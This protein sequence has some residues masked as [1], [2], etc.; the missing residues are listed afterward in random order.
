MAVEYDFDPVA[1]FD[2]WYKRRELSDRTGCLDD[3]ELSEQASSVYQRYEHNK[4]EMD[5]RCADFSK[6]LK[7]ADS[8]VVSKKNDLPNVSS[9]EV[10][11][12]VRRIARALVQN[13]PNVEV[14]SEFDDDSI[15]GVLAEHILKSKV[16]G[17]DE[18]SNDMQQNLFASTK[19]ALTIGFDAVVPCLLQQPDGSWYVEYDTIHHRDVFPEPGA[20]DVRRATEVFVRR[21]LTLGEVK[22]L[23][24][25]QVD[26]WDHDALRTMLYRMPKPPSRDRESNPHA[27]NERKVIAEGYEVITWYT[28]GGADFLT[29]CPRTKLLLR[30]EKNKHPRKLHPVFFLVLEK[31][32]EQPLGKSQVELVYGR[33]EFQDLMH[34]GAM[35][36]WY[37]NINPPLLG[38]GASNAIPNM[39]PGKYTPISNPNAKIEPFEV[40]TQTLLQYPSIAQGNLG[41]MVN[42]VGA[43]DQQMAVQAGNGMSATP[44]GVMAQESVVDTTTNNYQKA[45]ESFFSHYCSYALTMYM[46]EMKH[47][48][49]ILV[50]A[51]TRKKL[52][53]A[54]VDVSQISE[55]GTLEIDF[56]KMAVEYYVRCIPGSLI[57][58]EDEKQMRILQELFV[59]LSQALPAMAQMGDQ[60]VLAKASATLMF[61]L[62][63]QIELSG[64]NRSKD[65]ISLMKDGRT[66]QFVEYDERATKLEQDIGGVVSAQ[67]EIQVATAQTLAQMQEKMSLMMETQQVL[68]EKLGVANQQSE[69][70]PNNSEAV[71]MAR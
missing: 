35:K 70:N 21:Y 54:G 5:A 66:P 39:S 42:I 37:R 22:Q 41:S 63:K 40:S 65:M 51:E 25:D 1:E 2:Q 13:T 31:D 59:P 50:T 4:R 36:M 61:I 32:A 38:Y 12:I 24:R 9:G 67:A 19:T 20:K 18:Y 43:P 46:Q 44:Q 15:H 16:I 3:F 55:D 29:F 57:E 64:S 45:I 6:L 8:K 10:A 17:S 52:L 7:M 48:K 69:S 11:G 30:T 62:E 33:Q 23:I 56:S 28:S 58:L 60:T 68:L 53:N 34:N 14:I 49:E 47:V 71:A 27:D 26:G